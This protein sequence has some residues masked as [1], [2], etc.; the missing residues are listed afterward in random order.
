MNR[1]FIHSMDGQTAR[2]QTPDGR[3]HEVPISHMPPGSRPGFELDEDAFLAA[4]QARQ[5]QAAAP[6]QMPSPFMQAI[7]ASG[8][9]AH[10]SFPGAATFTGALPPPFAAAQAPATTQAFTPPAQ[11]QAVR[12]PPA[13][14]QAVQYGQGIQ[15][16]EMMAQRPM[17][18]AQPQMQAPATA[19][20]PVAMLQGPATPSAP[21]TA[22]ARPAVQTGGPP[23]MPVA[24][25]PA[26]RP[27]SP[28]DPA[29]RATPA[30]PLS[31]DQ[32][33]RRAQVKS[34]FGL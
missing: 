13:A 26:A 24:A 22:T 34:Q 4:H 27:P 14:V 11:P 16:A 30:T 15:S 1:S 3:I 6:V 20:S 12:P 33:A 29:P 31:L 23:I 9:S 7:A 10:A 25:A 8:Q 21:A 2:I 28:L 5:A 17:T 19:A 32:D 18:P